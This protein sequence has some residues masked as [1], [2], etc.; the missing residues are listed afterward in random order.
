MSYFVYTI[1]SVISF[2]PLNVLRYVMAHSL[3]PMIYIF[4]AFHVYLY[5]FFLSLS[6]PLW[7][8][9]YWNVFRNCWIDGTLQVSRGIMKRISFIIC[10]YDL[11]THYQDRKIIFLLRY[12]TVYRINMIFLVNIS[13]TFTSTKIWKFWRFGT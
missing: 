13:N 8:L 1:L 10:F 3:L 7:T 6:L 9:F 2:E 5:C 4:V 12:R 11:E